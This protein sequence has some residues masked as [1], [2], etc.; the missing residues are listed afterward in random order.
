MSA[1]FGRFAGRG[2][3]GAGERLAPLALM[4]LLAFILW[5]PAKSEAK[6]DPYYV[7]RGQEVSR[8][9]PRIIFVLDTSGSM[10]EKVTDSSENC[11]W[12][13]C[14]KA[15]HDGES[16]IS[17]A[18]RAIHSVVQ[19]SEDSANFALMAFGHAQPPEQNSEVPTH[20][21]TWEQGGFWN[22]E[23]VGQW[24]WE[25]GWGWVEHHYLGWSWWGWGLGWHWEWQEVWDW[26]WH[27][28]WHLSDGRRFQ[29]VDEYQHWAL[30]WDWWLGWYWDTSWRTIENDMGGEGYWMLC[31]DNR[32]FP[33]LRHDQLGVFTLPDDQSGPLPDGPLYSHYSS[34]LGFEDGVNAERPVQFMSRYLGPRFNLDCSDSNQLAL[35]NHSLGDFGSDDATRESNLCGRDFYYWPYVDGF[36]GYTGHESWSPLSS[37]FTECDSEGDCTEY[38]SQSLVA[39]VIRR[40]TTVGATLFSPFYSEGRTELDEYSGRGTGT[41]DPPGLDGDHRRSHRYDASRWAGRDRRDSVGERGRECRRVHQCCHRAAHSEASVAAEQCRLLSRECCFLSVLHSDR[42]RG[43]PVRTY[44]R[45]ADHRR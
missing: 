32:P 35:V 12:E 6:L 27:D 41:L 29:W 16:R 39:G 23:P 31:G 8:F 7:L 40:D 4:I 18:R 28:E 37:I 43:R 14:E 13:E 45:G 26:V 42:G 34:G 5:P 25:W 9:Q 24:V 15:D 36:P 11:R 10:N 20:C 1:L 22:W 3:A 17:A 44:E 2:Q 33:Y 30:S 21:Q 38:D 19:Q